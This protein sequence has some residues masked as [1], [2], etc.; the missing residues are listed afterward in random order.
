[1]SDTKK[2][3]GCGMVALSLL[4]LPL[5]LYLSWLIFNHISAT[6][7]MWALW[8][9]QIPITILIQVLGSVWKYFIEGDNK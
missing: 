2:V 1:M 4:T 5:S 9:V 6:P 3:F 8:W 7:L